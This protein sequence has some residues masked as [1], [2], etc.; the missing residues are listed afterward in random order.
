MSLR[1]N[2]GSRLCVFICVLL[3]SFFSNLN[4]FGQNISFSTTEPSSV[5]VCESAETFEI[6]FSNISGSTLSGVTI[7]LT[8][9]T[10]VEYVS[11]SLSES[12]AH[13]IQEQNISDLSNITL[14][15][16]DL[17]AGATVQFSVDALATFDAYTY[18]NSNW[19][20]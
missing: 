5:T 1:I 17:S 10:G 18:Q 20:Q 2:H 8:F 19:R 12:S 7:N 4:V 9:P 13:S 14:S 16:N 11:G 3:F 15:V 6:E